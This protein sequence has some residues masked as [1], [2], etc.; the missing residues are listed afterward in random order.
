MRF[1]RF[2]LLNA[3]ETEWARARVEEAVGEWTRHWFVDR[4]FQAPVVQP[5]EVGAC[6]TCTDDQWFRA[7]DTAARWV[8]VSMPMGER[9]HMVGA[10]GGVPINGNAGSAGAIGLEIAS[11]ALRDLSARMLSRMA[12]GGEAQVDGIERLPSDIAAIGA[13]Y[14]CM[15]I[16]VG[17]LRLT[18]IIAP[19]LIASDSG[20]SGADRVGDA[21]SRVEEALGGLL[22]GVQA[23]LGEAELEITSVGRMATGDVIRLES[24]VDLPIEISLDSEQRSAILA[25]HLGSFD[26]HRAL[27]LLDA[28]AQHSNR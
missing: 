3:T 8:G 9:G 17:G 4:R 21:L 2:K 24:H 7:L 28:K 1:R 15:S 5:G 16:D 23:W 19:D 6:L 11:A 22:V 18:A 13:G 14:A 20:V 26:G 25:G 27:Q 10:L 12:S